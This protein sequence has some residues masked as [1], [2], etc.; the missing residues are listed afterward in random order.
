LDLAFGA[1]FAVFLTLEMIRIWEIYP[2]GHVV[3]QFM[4]AFTDHRDSEILI[5]S[6]FSLLLGCALPKWMSSGLNDRPL[7]PFAGILSLGIGDTMAS[8]I[9]YKYGVLR[10]SKTGKKTI[11]GT[12][13][14]IT[15]VLAACSI[16]VS[17]LASSGYILS[18]N[19]LS[20]LVAVTLSGLLEAYTAQLDNAFIPLVFYSLLCL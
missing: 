9:G 17:L 2:L 7:A 12:A 1:A 10:W 15:S 20:L 5:V 4:N 19:W 18:Q 8:M 3:H 6:H 11:E 14:G 16:L 13:A